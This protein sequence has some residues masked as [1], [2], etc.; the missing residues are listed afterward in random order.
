MSITIHIPF[1]VIQNLKNNKKYKDYIG[2]P[3]LLQTL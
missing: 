1:N 2:L 3:G